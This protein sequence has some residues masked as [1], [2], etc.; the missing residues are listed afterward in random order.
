[1]TDK[2]KMQISGAGGGGSD[3]KPHTPYEAPNT[4][5][6]VVKGRIL[7]LIAYGPI[8][9]LVN[10]LKSVYLEDTPV[11]NDD[12]TFNF[13]GIKLETRVGLPD[14]DYIPGFIDVQNTAEINTEVLFANPPVRAISNNSADAVVVTV[15]LA[16][17]VQQLE[18]GDSVN[19]SVTVLIDYRSG[20]GAWIPGAADTITG[21]TTSPFPKSYRVE[22]T[23]PGP[24]SI[25]VRRANA[26]STTSKLQDKLTWTL[27]TEVIDKKFTYPNMALVGITVNSKLFGTSMPS[28][29]YD[30]KLSIISVPSN[31]DPETR[32][33]TGLWNGQFKQA[34]TDNPAWAFM[35]LAMHPVIG[36]G[37]K[38]VDKWLLYRIAQYCDELVPDGYGGM[39]PRFTINT[40]FAAEEE[41]QVALA[42]LASIF[43]GMAYWGTNT[44]VPV[45]DMP[46]TPVKIV[47]LANVVGGEITYVGTAMSERHSVCTV[48]WNDPNDKDTSV[49]EIY[50]DPD[51][52][53]AFGWRETRVTAVG[54]NSRGQ[55]LRMA[56]WILY[57]ER[58][59]TQTISYEATLDHANLRP[60]DIIEVADP[61]YQGA[62]MAGRVVVGGTKVITLDQV[63]PPEVMATT[64]QWWL[65]VLQPDG[66]VLKSEI[67]SFSGNT[68]TLLK[69]MPAAP[70]AGFMWA[71]SAL[72]IQ[73][74]QYRVVSN[75]ENSSSG[76]YSI[77][78][79]EYDPNKYSFVEQGL[80]LPDRPTSLLPTGPIAPPMDLSFEVYTYFAG[81]T[82]HQGLVISW[83]PPKDIR[84][85][86]YVLD[87]MDPTGNGAFRTVFNSP[88]TSFDLKDAVG[89]RWTIRVRSISSD[90]VPSL[91]ESR[92]IQVAMM[93]LP[94]PPDSVRVTEGTFDIT[95]APQSAYRDSLWEF[96][97]SNVALGLTEIESNATQLPTGTYLVDANLR[98]ARTYYYYIR[99]VNQY[100]LSTWFATQGTTT[101]D[102]DDVMDHIKEDFIDG[103]LNTIL[104]EKIVIVAGEVATD[105]IAPKIEE[106]RGELADQKAE[107][108]QTI[109]ELEQDVATQGTTLQGQ[110]NQAKQDLEAQLGTLDGKI[111]AVNTRVT[112]TETNLQGQ[113]TQTKTDLQ[114][115]N[116]TLSNRI[117]SNKTEIQGQV[118]TV[119]NDLQAQID[120]IGQ[121]ANSGIYDPAKA[122]LKGESVRHG[123]KLYQA[124][125]AV[126]VGKT[127]PDAAYWLD[128]GQIVEDSNGLATRVTVAEAAIVKQAGEIS[129]NSSSITRLTADLQKQ[130]LDNL[131]QGAE[132]DQQIADALNIAKGSATATESL[133]ATVTQQGDKLT[134][135]G[136]S[137]TELT[138]SLT[139]TN[140]AIG[141]QGSA[142]E[143][144]KSI[145]TSLGNSLTSQGESITALNNSLTVTN[146]NVTAAQAAANAANTL[147]G[148]K[149]KVLVQSSAPAVADQLTQNLWI[150]TT[151]NANT[152]K[153]W[154]GSAWVAVTDKV[155]SDAAA[156]AANALTVANTKADASAVSSLT[157]RVSA[158]EGVITSQGESLTALNNSLT[159][160][161]TKVT[162]AQAAAD[163]AAT[164]AGG[165][166]KVL[167]QNAAPAAA[168]QLPQNLWI[169][170]TNNANTPKR[171]SGSAWL[172]VTDKVAT[173]AAAAAANALTVANTKADA[174]AVSSLTTRVTEAE[175]KLTSQ[176]QSITELNN[177]LV[178]TNTNVATAQAA[179]NAANTLAGGKGKVL[180]QPGAPAVADQLPQNL[181][182]DTT[183]GANTPK[184]WTGSAWAAVTDKVATDAAAAA[185]DALAKVALKADASALA[186]LTTTVTQQG[187]LITAN[188]SS[189]TKLTADLQTMELDNLYQGAET[190]QQIADALN[191]ATGAA[192]AT[193][194]LTATVTQQD[195]V[196]TAQGQQ[197][198]ELTSSLGNLGG[199]IVGAGS[200][201]ESLK[202]ITTAQGNAI[203]SQG[204]SLTA[205]NNSLTVTNTNVTA[206]QAAADAA[207]TLAG[208]KGKVLV[209]SGAPAVADQLPQNLW[210]DTT[211]GANTPKR[212]SGSTW[213]AVTDK[214]ATDAAA[215]AV[216]A[217]SVANTKADASA[218]TS[219]TTR[220]T[221]AEGL[222]TS[223]GT[224]IT[225]LNNSLV[226]TNTNVTAAQK[227][228][229]DANTLAGGKGKVI[230]QTGAPAVAD[231]LPQNLWIDITG[232]ANTPKR[233]TGSAWAAVTDKVATD[234]AAAA[235][236]ALSVA[237]TKADAS[238]LTSLT[239]R[240][241]NA[242]GV[243]TSQGTAITQLNNS[244][245]TTNTNVTAAQQAAQAAADKAGAKGEVIYGTTAPA[246]D[247]QLPQNLWIDTTANANTPKRWSGSAWVAVTDKV[248]TDAAAAAAN[249]LSVANS[250]ADASALTSLTTRVTNAEGVLSTQGTAIT[251]LNNSLVTT[252]TNVTAAQNAANAAN[253]LAGGKGKV[254]VQAAAPAA[255][256]QLVQNL[257]IDITGGANTPKR[258]SGSA[259][260]AVTDKV[261]TDAAAAAANALSVANSKADASAVTSLTTRVT[262]AEGKLTTQGES[263]TSLNNSLTITNASVTA[264]QNAANAANTL[265]GGKGKVLVQPGAPAA[266]DQLAQNLWIDTTGNAN[267]PKRWT[268]SAWAAVTDKVAT[269]AATAAADALAK[270]A[271]KADASALT[272]LTTTVTQ[273]G[274][275]ISANST[276]ITKLTADLQMMELD[277]LYHGAETDQQIA[278]ALNIATGAATATTS[279]TATVTQQGGK[280]EAQGQS[281]T[282]LTASLSNL[283][284]TIG[285]AG[286]AIENLKT[287]TTA[288][289]NTL[290]SYGESLTALNNSLTVTNTNVT[291]AQNAANAANTLA[292]G[293]GKVLV[294]SGAP[295]AADQLPQNLWIDTTG[296]ANTPK[297]WTGSAWAA[298]T[299]K[300]ATDAAAAAANA[301]TV[302]NTKADA[303]AVSSLT[304]R[305]TAAEGLITSQGQSIT[306]LNNS[307][308][309]TNTNVTA[310]QSAADAA[311][312]LAGGKGKVLV[313]TATP[314]AADQLPQN[315]WIDITGGANTPKRW[316]GSAW[317]AV[318]DKV[319]TDAAAAA[320]NAL[321]VANTKADASAL[322]SLTTR[323]TSAEGLI[324]SQG[325]AITQLN[326]S[327]TTTNTNVTAAQNAANAANT[328][329]GGKGKVIVQAAAPAAADQLVQNLWIDITGNANTPKRWTGSAWVAVS[330]KLATDAAAAA[331]NALTQVALKADASALT[332]LTNVVTQQGNT[333]SAQGT[334]LT[335]LET[336][337][338]F[339]ELDQ[340]YNGD[341]TDAQI[342]DALMIAKGAASATESLTAGVTQQGDLITAQGQSLTELKTSLTGVESNLGA[343]G[344]AIESLKTITTAQ[345]NSLTS[346]GESITSLNNSLTITNA[347]VTAAQNAANA[348]NT[349]A[350]GKGK[351]LVQPGAPAVA[352][353]LAQNL[354]IDTT[355]NANT[356]KRWTGSAWAAVTD[357]VA[358]DAAAAA[359]NALTQVQTKA[360]ASA[361]TALTTRVTSVEG[362]T[363]ALS[364][365]VTQL[366]TKVTNAET[367]ITANANAIAQVDVKVT[368]INGKV[369]TLATRTDGIYAQVNPVMAGDD[370]G[371]LAG[372]NV[373]FV[374]VWT[375]QTARI[376]DGVALGKRVDQ[377]QASVNSANAVIQS[378]QNV[379][380]T[381][382]AANSAKTDLVQA[383]VTEVAASVQVVANANAALSGKVG[384][385]Y[386]VKLQVNQFGQYVYAGYG[387]AIEDGPGGLTST[388]NI[389]ADKFILSNPLNGGLEI[390]FAVENG[391]TY[392]KSAF[393]KAGTIDMLKI[394]DNL[395]STDYIAGQRGWKLWQGGNLEFNG[396][397]AGGGR[398]SMT[399]QLIQVFSPS[400]A[401][402]LR[403]G[404]W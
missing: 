130:E 168:D 352:D 169:D 66:T 273:Q 242:E 115:V 282:E 385:M 291:A 221:S 52:I 346:Q 332:A 234:A 179:A 119:K 296:N 270:V 288:Q 149:G 391:V 326:N 266:A 154:S 392:I 220:V 32:V 208:G 80:K 91:W 357:K 139:S 393:I 281:I 269:D 303:S 382:D 96:W 101:A 336:S 241:T 98:S 217:L 268:G 182:I 381:A 374:G 294:Q 187:N 306:Q 252:N 26:E 37:I 307:L 20:T 10:G 171:W 2:P 258:W 356:P 323:V 173:D 211:A 283:D 199:D 224:A 240:V 157:T 134:A 278:D 255:A 100:G 192:T 245:V 76:T 299:D 399:N 99:G 90:G 209:Q 229:D 367:G 236:N 51:S 213:T 114:G 129:V 225:Q 249:A 50:E 40:L 116:T 78:A 112:N 122:Y 223:Q 322:N 292:G 285:G 77:T 102:F 256:D 183:G 61:D 384:A 143:S 404:I 198:T 354:W 144:L 251:Q 83:T 317:A 383:S 41:A 300:V 295:A 280:I 379:M 71:L 389:S 314:A 390:P 111:V 333:I 320:A 28:R 205:L 309:T 377:T 148:G 341:E 146:T 361:L 188:S 366:T 15:Q 388:F 79:T 104:T 338:H 231:Q 260:L 330:D 126:P 190:D 73:L 373:E 235:A 3:K 163:A 137:I 318:T 166:G 261:A 207:N 200:A 72:N 372:D 138:S 214:V 228:A 319:A 68:V 339:Q 358:T 293:K 136:Q 364:S 334:N 128:V 189:I 58:M 329:A 165:K 386:A 227:A 272:A 265:A 160:T 232:G 371:E 35:D 123:Q 349:L 142:I 23:G 6:S 308:V 247:K 33:Y 55:A 387:L 184:R 106:V 276:S 351:V 215:A 196:I 286:T 54:C 257:W 8:H 5:Q 176:G 4:L 340:L 178:T 44:V 107:I 152:P 14:Q 297:R 202:T 311:N 360:D 140:G 75:K 85:D 118:T 141:A 304:T 1:M 95:L 108:D 74:P 92:D 124:L 48:M 27:L 316:T 86:S 376:E 103:E 244:L 271:L 337:L 59:E 125:Q 84:V 174:S 290:T 161:N 38:Y 65:S 109:T 30:M 267:T 172:P 135:Q 67:S 7:D 60:G 321:T 113:I 287:I 177:S 284:G 274:N 248:A 45:G 164:L 279:L 43:R 21:K 394:G 49:P 36:A 403:L 289:G 156:A 206:A 238:A 298:V 70:E 355:G 203:S 353:Q 365:S 62:R 400:G 310:A 378:V 22:L 56:K 193:S 301:L 29:S 64:T 39:E 253:T 277:N 185:A 396:S 342:A 219:L 31:Y 218:V 9:G 259:W 11:Q 398:L 363:S 313:Q 47:S 105:L 151:G 131:Y 186:L 13:E 46:S 117:D 19:A 18:N 147:A 344:S 153:R 324:T 402:K 380:A 57:S 181:W 175:G 194:A 345:G 42:N 239:T 12:D 368:D 16:A 204:E 159:I 195:G 191:I 305:V 34:W 201:I 325:T 210:I 162:T 89:G 212:W 53:V 395:Q 369:T 25:R 315:L 237:N 150:D 243:I 343:Q 167:V 397:V 264:A 158:A 347:S 93:L 88:G 250:K 246:A 230:V 132:T 97:R 328:L 17:L 170:T 121:L 275:L 94:V 120:A 81:T 69:T 254:I 362:T 24:F 302:A 327:L 216:N 375:E 350:G 263:I 348:A 87:V 155:A 401:L 82:R 110:I 331:A 226:T 233:W 335:Q 359:A 222:I 127:P 133:T 63:P 370:S 262:E 180:V 197:L 312:A 145:T